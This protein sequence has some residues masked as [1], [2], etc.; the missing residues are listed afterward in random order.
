MPKVIPISKSQFETS[1]K[2]GLQ[3]FSKKRNTILIVRNTGG[4]GD[5]L[6]MRM[7]F[8]DFKR[9]MPDVKIVFACP[10]AYHDAVKDHPFIDKILDSTKVDESEYIINYNVTTACG[11]YEYSIAPRSDKHRSDIWAEHCG[12]QLEHHDMHISIPND[13]LSK[14]RHQ[15][16][17][18][19][20]GKP[21]VLFSPISAMPSKDLDIKQ[22]T[23]VL[24]GLLKR[25]YYI[26]GFHNKIIPELNCN[27]IQAKNFV[28]F[29]GFIN[30]AD[31]IVSVDTAAL[32]AAGGCKKTCL[33]IFSWADGYVYTKYY[34]KCHVV[35]KHRLTDSNWACGPCYLWSRCVKQAVGPR[36]PCIS[37]LTSDLILKEF[38]VMITKFSNYSLLS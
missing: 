17:E 4:L 22:R 9:V 12:L 26:V 32:H 21:I 7:I 13:V 33:G 16:E 10:T 25:N 6:M 1:A 11:D 31:V 15:L 35:Q 38:D 18:N 36:K 28:E 27:Q 23:E 2:L 29:L 3:E 20:N 5:I 34:P 24:D 14:C 37:E 8:E 19:S 30:A